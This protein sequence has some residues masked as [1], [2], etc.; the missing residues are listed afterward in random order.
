M[1]KTK[2]QEASDKIVLALFPLSPEQRV[3]ALLMSGW[4]Y[5]HDCGY[6]PP[7]D[8]PCHCQNDE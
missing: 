1:G 8:G 4:F 5:C 3:E 7:P 6:P 2:E